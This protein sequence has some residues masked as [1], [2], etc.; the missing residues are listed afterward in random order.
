MHSRSRTSTLKLKREKTVQAVKSCCHC[1]IIGFVIVILCTIMQLKNSE[2]IKWI[3]S[4]Y[5]VHYSRWLIYLIV[6]FFSF[7]R[8]FMA[9]ALLE[10]NSTFLCNF[11]SDFASFLKLCREFIIRSE[12]RSS[13][14]HIKCRKSGCDLFLTRI[15][16][17][18]K[19]RWYDQL[20]SSAFCT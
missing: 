12:D 14:M 16:S 9:V 17:Y 13:W 15:W 5:D 4:L 3:F 18:E 19:E 10:F 6:T 7:F 20:I 2:T 8:D 1:P 11:S